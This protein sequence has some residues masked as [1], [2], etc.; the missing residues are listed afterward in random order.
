MT[1]QTTPTTQIAVLDRGFV[2][3]GTCRIDGDM[4]IITNAQNVRRWGTDKGLGQL[5][6]T[7]PTPTT[8]LDPAGTVR[9]PMRSL[10]HLIDCNAAVWPTPQTQAA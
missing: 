9:A 2:Y 6:A 8:K 7:G 4:L 10:I 1:N 3:I 5:A